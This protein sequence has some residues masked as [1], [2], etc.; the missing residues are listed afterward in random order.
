VVS[1]P[2]RDN[3]SVSRHRFHG[4]P[5]RFEAIARFIDDRYGRSV[6]F[7]ADVAGGQGMLTRILRKQ[8]NYDAEVV[9]PRGW[10]LRGVPV[11]QEAF[12]SDLAMFYDLVIG[13]HPD[14]ALPA[15]VEAALHRPAVIV[16]CCNFFDQT[17]RLG[18]DDLLK[19]IE[20]RLIRGRVHVERRTF[21]FRGP[22]NIALVTEPNA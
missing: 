1:H 9:D 16:P 18:R 22:F 10:A 6:T 12:T 3:L 21:D 17:H 11:R 4:D 15:V 7:V 2:R 8:Y 13:L 20:R 14:E 19:A 5:A